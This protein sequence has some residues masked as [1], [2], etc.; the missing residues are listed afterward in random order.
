MG[1]KLQVF[2]LVAQHLGQDEGLID[3]DQDTRLTVA[4]NAVWDVARKA[5]L[6]KNAWNFAIERR[7]LPALSEPPAFGFGYQYKL[8]ED[9][10]RLADVDGPVPQARD[11]KLEGGKL[12][13]NSSP[14][15]ILYVRDC[16]E[17]DRW[18]DLFELAVS[19][20]VAELIAVQITGDVNVKIECRNSFNDLFGDA[21]AA[22]AQE[23]PPQEFDEDP[24][25][26]ARWGYGYSTSWPG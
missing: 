22:D 1:S 13:G 19:F 7:A 25:V 6:R 5:T 26:T 21:Q 17:I 4:I 23:N 16:I 2:S 11:W 15:Q 10:V 20:K 12:L 8:P 14:L 9:F 24:W 18:D 3:P